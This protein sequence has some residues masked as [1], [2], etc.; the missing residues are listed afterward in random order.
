MKERSSVSAMK[1][2][3]KILLGIVTLFCLLAISACGGTET[4]RVYDSARVLNSS[5]VQAAARNVPA[6]VDIYTVN[7]FTGTQADFQRSVAGKLANDANRIVMGIDTQHNYQYVA[8]G[9]EIPLNSSNI[10]QASNAFA[11][12]YGNGDYTRATVASLNSLGQSMRVNGASNVNRPGAS[13]LPWLL[14]LLIIGGLLFFLTKMRR[15]GLATQ[16]PARPTYQ[17]PQPERP[18]R[19]Y[20][21]DQGARPLQSTERPTYTER[22][23]TYPYDQ[24]TANLPTHDKGTVNPPTHDKGL[25][26]AGGAAAGGLGYELGKR[27]G[28]VKPPPSGPESSST[29]YGGKGYSGKKKPDTGGG[30]TYGK[31][32]ADYGTTDTGGGG[33]YG[34][35]GADY[36]T[37]DTG[38]GGTYGKGGADYDRDRDR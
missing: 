14:P 12:N 3:W 36:G 2:P 18:A 8:R 31:G 33:R 26:A 35:G 37:T 11:A 21:Y 9:S 32:G 19:D 23:P 27:Q 30:G 17:P 4:A 10:A 24:G 28:E 15:P 13:P 5:R 20:S 1:S 38:G 16:S 25:G 6:N 7:R 22:P 29:E 34:K